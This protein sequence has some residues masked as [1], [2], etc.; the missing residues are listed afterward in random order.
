MDRYKLITVPQYEQYTK[1]F[2]LLTNC[3]L[4]FF[5]Q[6]RVGVLSAVRRKL[7]TLDDFL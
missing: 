6:M 5:K 2:Q 4:Q 7:K 3:C 1:T